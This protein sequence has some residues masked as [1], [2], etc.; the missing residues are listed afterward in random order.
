MSAS[1]EDSVSMENLLHTTGGVAT[2]VVLVVIGLA[3]VVVVCVLVCAYYYY[4]RRHHRHT[5]TLS[6]TEDSLSP[7]NGTPSNED[8]TPFSYSINSLAAEPAFH[9]T[10][11][12]S[13]LSNDELES[14]SRTA[15]TES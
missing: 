7:H 12:E 9:H 5:P 15:H 13:I 11:L 2:M 4:W 8:T 14:E 1:G 3:V 10:S 6:S